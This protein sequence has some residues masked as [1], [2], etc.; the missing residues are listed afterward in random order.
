[1]GAGGWALKM[2]QGAGLEEIKGYGTFP[3]SGHFLRTD[4]PEIVAK[5]N[6][7]VYS[8]APVGA[9]PMSVPH[10]DKRVVDGK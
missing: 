9:P 5:H 8:Q 3:V 7:K 6:A 4:N 1:M 2:L 10:L